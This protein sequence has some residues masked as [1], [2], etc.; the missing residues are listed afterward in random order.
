MQ[1]NDIRVDSSYFMVYKCMYFALRFSIRK[2]PGRNSGSQSLTER[3]TL[4]MID[5]I[6][7]SS[8]QFG[9]LSIAQ[10]GGKLRED[11]E[12]ERGCS[13]PNSSTEVSFSLSASIST[14]LSSLSS[15]T[16]GKSF[17]SSLTSLCPVVVTEFSVVTEL[18]S[19]SAV[20]EAAV[21]ASMSSSGCP[22][23]LLAHPSS[24]S[25]PSPSSC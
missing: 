11:H 8:F 6:L 17:L 3:L 15:F 1:Y 20:T 5:R 23:P 7:A 24:S 10:R 12:K 22:P 16:S 25:P 9:T 2:F 18:S 21:V 4:L 14:S 19:S 13:A